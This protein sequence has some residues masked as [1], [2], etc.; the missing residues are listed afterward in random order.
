MR[1]NTVD[2]K[3]ELTK[4]V[5]MAPNGAV[6]HRIRALKAVPAF[7]IERGNIGGYVES[8]KNLSHEGNS[9]V[10]HRV[11]VYGDAIVFGKSSELSGL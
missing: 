8:Q 4:Q 9:F 6:L 1:T 3:Y 7:S 11:K 10:F 2:K 5:V